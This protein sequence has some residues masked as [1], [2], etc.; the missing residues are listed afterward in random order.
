MSVFCAPDSPD[1]TR[2][3]FLAH[4]MK[5]ALLRALMCNIFPFFCCIWKFH[6]LFMHFKLEL[7][8]DEYYNLLP[9]YLF[10]VLNQYEWFLLSFKLCL[11]S[12]SRATLDWLK[13]VRWSTH[14]GCTN[15]PFNYFFNGLTMTLFANSNIKAIGRA[16][17]V[18]YLLA[19]DDYQITLMLSFLMWIGNV[20]GRIHGSDASWEHDNEPPAQVNN[21]KCI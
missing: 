16:L 10:N 13:I 7:F 11:V 17:I 20:F 15:A 3:V 8:Y 9:W 18:I 21:F 14:M 12:L 1:W 6:F 2:Y 19:C 5:L 4:V